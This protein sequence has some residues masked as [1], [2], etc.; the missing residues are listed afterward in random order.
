MSG[1]VLYGVALLHIFPECGESI[2]KLS[3]CYPTSYCITFL[4]I[5]L[6]V[7]MSNMAHGHTHDLEAGDSEQK[8]LCEEGGG[9]HEHHSQKRWAS[10]LVLLVS[11][12]I[13]DISEGFALGFTRELMSAVYMFVGIA[14]HKW[15]DVSCQVVCGIKQG[16]GMRQNAFLAA[17]LALSTPLAQM[18]GYIICLCSDQAADSG[19]LEVAED[20]FMSFACGTFLA[21]AFLEIVGEELHGR[22]RRDVLTKG[23]TILCGFLFIALTKIVETVTE[24]C[25]QDLS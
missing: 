23:L 11:L 7:M 12:L 24:G 18:V 10:A 17:I 25:E 1:G 13:H 19:S 3:N 2:N 4:G 20:F 21:I 22:P 6:V 9:D 15:C 16:M 5:I 14:L 8:H